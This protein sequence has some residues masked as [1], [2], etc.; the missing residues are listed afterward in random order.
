MRH[1]KGINLLPCSA[2]IIHANPTHL[3]AI[4]AIIHAIQ[5]NIILDMELVVITDYASAERLIDSRGRI[6]A[7]FVY[8][9]ELTEQSF[10]E[11]AL[12]EARGFAFHLVDVS[13]P[14]P[15]RWYVPLLDHLLDNPAETSCSDDQCFNG[16]HPFLSSNSSFTTATLYRTDAARI[17][18]EGSNPALMVTS[19]GCMLSGI[20]PT[21][22]RSAILVRCLQ[23]LISQTLPPEHFEVIV[24]DD[25]STDDTYEQVKAFRAPYSIVYLR[26]ENSGPAAA[27]NMG[28][29]KAA[30]A[31]ILFLNDDA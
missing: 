27:R 22:N 6:P 28:I 3:A 26:Q 9:A 30:G 21:F 1:T 16:F 2:T 19:G 31:F 14:L 17:V 12:K 29:R 15:Q 13:R 10:I 4:N 24:C 25:G 18:A 23:H 8:V 7:R 5:S 20:I 11:A